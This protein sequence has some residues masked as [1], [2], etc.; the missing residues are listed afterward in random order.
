MKSVLFD[1]NIILDIALKREPFFQ[2]AIKLFTLIDD[3]KI[4]GFVTATTITDIY[5]LSKKANGHAKTIQ[6][7]ESLL[8]IVEIIGVD[9]TTILK[10]ISLKIKDFEDGIQV[11]ATLLNDIEVIITRNEKDFIGSNVIVNTP[12]EFLK[13]YQN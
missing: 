1:T 6:F 12:N 10:A 4:V 3:Q 2:D 11:S 9:K 8:K 13:N 7:I 5:Y